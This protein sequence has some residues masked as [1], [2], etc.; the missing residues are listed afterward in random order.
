VSVKSRLRDDHPELLRH[1]FRVYRPLP[2]VRFD[3]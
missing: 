2:N 1:R 3:A